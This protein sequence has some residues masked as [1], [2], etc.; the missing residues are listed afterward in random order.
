MKSV[1]IISNNPE[2]I[3]A[4]GTKITGLKKGE[5]VL[6]V[7]P[8]DGGSAYA[9]VVASTVRRVTGVSIS[10]D[11]ITI[12]K[13]SSIDI[14]V[15]VYPAD[16]DNKKVVLTSSDNSLLSVDGLTATALEN[17]TVEVTATTE[18]GGFV[19]KS[20]ITIVGEYTW[21]DYSKP[22]E[23]LNSEDVNHIYSNIKTI[24]SMLLLSGR[25][26]E[27]LDEVHIGKDTH[28]GSM[29]ALLQ[30]IEYNID[31]ISENDCKSI[32]YGYPAYID[33]HAS[34]TNDIWRWIQILNEMYLI[35]TGSFGKWQYVLLADGCPTIQ[36][37]RLLIRG[38]KVG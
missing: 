32:Y 22:I 4:E 28:Y 38:E 24:R 23:I 29:F 33:S 31:K 12:A 2:I 35:L 18:D 5:A 16:A 37:K 9:S 1:Y 13:G 20:T 6:T 8:D 15:S 14:V 25:D 10:P 34:N 26:V 3:S 17:G 21:Y 30:N 19:A 11:E 27:Q 36:G 7:L